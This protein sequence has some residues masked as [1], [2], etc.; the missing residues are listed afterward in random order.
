M[1]DVALTSWWKFKLPRQ[2][3]IAAIVP[4]ILLF[5]RMAL[6]E[7][8]AWMG[9]VIT[10]AL[11]VLLTLTRWPYGALVVLIGMSTMARFFIEIFGW[12]ARP[13]HFAVAIVSLAICIWGLRSKQKLR[14]ETPDYW[15]LGYI[16][17][18]FASSTFGSSSPSDTLRWALLNSLA[19]LPY[20]LVRFSVRDAATL[21][22][23]FQ[24]LLAIGIAESAYGILCYV[25]HHL[26]GTAVGME[27][28]QYLGDV[29]APYGSLAEANL[30][31]AY[32]G[33]TAVLA[34]AM[35]LIGGRRTGYLICFF[36]GS[37]AVVLSLSRAALV[38]TVVAACW[39]GWRARNVR[40]RQ[41]R[42]T[43][44][45]IA[46]VAMILII[47]VPTMGDVVHER[48]ANILSEGRLGEQTTIGR[49]IEAQE[50]LQ[51]FSEHRLIGS[52]TASLQLSFDW[53]KYVPGMR[54][55]NSWVGNITIRIL[56][57]TGLVGLA[58]ALGLLGSLWWKI[59]WVLRARASAAPMLVALSAGTLLYAVSFQATDGTLLAF[60]WVHLGLLSSAA[61]SAKSSGENA[62]GG[63]LGTLEKPV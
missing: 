45:L 10:G 7:D 34:L 28:G 26:F 18:N 6:E 5:C 59:R 47:V 63:G 43:A 19:I 51:E 55:T 42:H 62:N 11:V 60:P 52:G 13:E 41:P 21:R 12:K 20:F 57:D 30:F 4:L 48:F 32:T 40:E 3:E 2:L 54:D 44:A 61:L 1:S 58:I 14:L 8:L 35:Y 16:A 23:A 37:I 22:K 15:L 29:A 9:W 53:S 24:I 33:C 27:V 46:A 49:L 36:I 56:H 38:A 39:V 25:L 17:M 31:G 50:A